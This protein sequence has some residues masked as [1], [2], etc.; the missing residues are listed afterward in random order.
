MTFLPGSNVTPQV[1]TQY[2]EC[3]VG[4]SELIER[5]PTR[6]GPRGNLNRRKL[7]PSNASNSGNQPNRIGIQELLPDKLGLVVRELQLGE[8]KAEI[9]MLRTRPFLWGC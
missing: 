1:L 3:F 5:D 8:A 4:F 6:V 2:L 7:S 9:K